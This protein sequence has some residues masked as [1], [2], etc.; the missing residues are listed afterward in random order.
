[1]SRRPG[2]ALHRRHVLVFAVVGA[3]LLAAIVG[4]AEGLRHPASDDPPTLEEDQDELIIDPRV[5]S[6]C[7]ELD[8][9]EDGAAPAS[10]TPF[11]PIEVSSSGLLD[12]PEYYDGKVVRYQGEIVGGLLHRRGGV[13]AHVNDDVYA[14]RT[15]RLPAHRAYRGGNAGV[16]VLLSGSTAE[17]VTRVGGPEDHGDVL[18]VVGV[19]RRADPGTREVA[20]IQASRADIVRAGAPFQDPPLRDRDIAAVLLGAV[21]LSTVGAERILARRWRRS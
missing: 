3:A 10:R 13:W 9:A 8:D 12:C 17:Q 1:M 5:T 2:Q 21:A 14:N 7:P 18:D 16:G 4:L 19:F 11:P 6:E 15:D 20:V